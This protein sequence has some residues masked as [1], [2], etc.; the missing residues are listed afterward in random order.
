MPPGALPVLVLSACG[1]LSLSLLQIVFALPGFDMTAR[2]STMSPSRTSPGPP[3]QPGPSRAPTR[4]AALQRKAEKE[5]MLPR[6]YGYALQDEGA[7]GGTVTRLPAIV[8][9]RDNVEGWETLRVVSTT[10]G[11][12]RSPPKQARKEAGRVRLLSLSPL[13]PLTRAR[14]LCVSVQTS[15]HGPLAVASPINAP[16][17][18]LTGFLRGTRCA[19]PSV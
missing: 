10:L 4:S 1:S 5:E 7:G 11:P 18:N 6:V 17:K 15:Q 13:P 12:P 3:G 16:V 8:A 19:A 2:H 9:D 14:V